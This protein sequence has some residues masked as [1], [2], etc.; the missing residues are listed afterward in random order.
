MNK[1]GFKTL[2]LIKYF[3]NAEKMPEMF[4]AIKKKKKTKISENIFI[5]PEINFVPRLLFAAHLLLYPI[6]T[7]LALLICTCR[8]SGEA[9][10]QRDSCLQHFLLSP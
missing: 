8:C 6:L 3:S 10:K 9:E 1:Q 2:T 4:H 7:L 5:F